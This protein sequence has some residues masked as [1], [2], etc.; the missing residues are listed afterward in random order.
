MSGGNAY[1]TDASI[2]SELLTKVKRLLKKRLSPT[3]E[4][5]T[6]SETDSLRPRYQIP[7]RQRVR[8]RS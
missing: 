4:G 8:I 2:I 3:H 5:E 1:R 6:V 7:P